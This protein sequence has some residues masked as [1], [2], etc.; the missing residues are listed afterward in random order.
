[1]TETPTFTNDSSD[2]E[3]TVLDNPQRGC[4]TLER[5]KCYLRGLGSGGNGVLPS[6]VSIDPPIPF[7]EIGTNGSFTRSF[8]KIDGLTLQLATSANRLYEPEGPNGSYTEIAFDR[9]VGHGLYDTRM[10][11]P[12]EEVHRHTDRI[13]HRATLDP[14]NPGSVGNGDWGSMNVSTQTDLLMRAGESYYPDPEDYAAEARKHGLSKAIPISASREPPTIV[15]GVTRCW[16]MHPAAG[17][18]DYGGAVIGYSYLSQPVFTQPED[19]GLPEYVEEYEQNG[20]I[21]VVDIEEPREEP[22]DTNDDNKNMT[23]DDAINGGD[24]E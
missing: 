12:K 16:V 20:K 6:W 13:E 19:G 8:K 24:S 15:P 23:L 5:G 17:D 2:D 21:E 7:R 4:G 1:M 3:M 22:T 9:M 14:D 11:I 10:E 18:G